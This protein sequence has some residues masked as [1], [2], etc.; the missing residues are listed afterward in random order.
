MDPTHPQ[1]QVENATAPS[2]GGS[3]DPDGDA[4]ACSDTLW[5][6]AVRKGS[7]FPDLPPH[8]HPESLAQRRRGAVAF[9]SW[10]GGED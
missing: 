10:L 3:P 7:H 2:A 8:S 5:L 1:R 6:E 9:S 4:A